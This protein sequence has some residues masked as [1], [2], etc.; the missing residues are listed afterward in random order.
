MV[1]G[2]ASGDTTRNVRVVRIQSERTLGVGDDRAGY[3]C[4]TVA[5]VKRKPAS[6]VTIDDAR[7]IASKLPRSYEVVVRG[8][9]KFRIGAIVYVAFS[10]DETIMEF[11]FPK[12]WRAALVEAEP[13]KFSLPR[14]SD[15]RFHWICVRLDKID[16][17]ELEKLIVEAWRMCVPKKVSTAYDASQ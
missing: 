1:A 4:V 6:P 12:D 5:R 17:E 7:A 9:L 3:D 8:R 14:P 10:Q 16:H 13:E 15:L 11:A 2:S